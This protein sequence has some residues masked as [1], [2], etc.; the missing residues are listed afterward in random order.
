MK[1][2]FSY[3]TYYYIGVLYRN[4]EKYDT[5]NKKKLWKLKKCQI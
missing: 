4:H 5:K 2:L 3:E 1:I